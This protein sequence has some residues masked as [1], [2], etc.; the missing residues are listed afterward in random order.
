MSELNWD[1]YPDFERWEF[2]CSETGDCKMHP[3]FM[4]RLQALRTEYGKP[5]SINSGYRSPEHPIEA[6]KDEPGVHSTGRAVDVPVSHTDAY[7]LMMLAL[8][9]GFI[10]VGVNQKG[11]TAQR[12]L[13][14]DDNPDYPNPRIW[15]Y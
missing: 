5:I 15:S 9:H 11:A 14:L 2:Q 4:A 13:H 3:D 12:Y 10:R 6:A 1:D 8:K 7:M